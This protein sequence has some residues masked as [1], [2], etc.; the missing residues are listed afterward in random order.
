MLHVNNDSLNIFHAN[1][2]GLDC[3]QHFST[4]HNFISSN[5]IE[6]DI[7]NISETSQQVDENF[8]KNINIDSYKQPYTTETI[9]MY[10]KDKYTSFERNDLK[11]RDNDFEGVWAEIINEKSKNIICGC[12]YI[13]TQEQI[14]NHLMHI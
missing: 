4:L 1:V 13:D 7:I 3:D 12:V 8:V 9:L 14:L 2:N 5:P 11:I 6:F 10:I